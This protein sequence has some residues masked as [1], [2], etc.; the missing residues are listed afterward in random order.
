[1]ALSLAKVSPL[2]RR[3]RAWWEG[4]ELG[5]AAE[6][7]PQPAAAPPAGR[8]ETVL[9]IPEGRKSTLFQQAEIQLRERVWGVG[10]DGPGDADWVF[11]FVAPLA[12]DNKMTVAHLGAGLG[13]ITRAIAGATG[14]WTTGYEARADHAEA[15][16][17]LSTMAGQVKRAPVVGY[18]PPA[19]PKD[20][21]KC[22]AVIAVDAF[23]AIADKPALY[24]SV[25]GVLRTDGHFLFTDY[26][27]K[28]G[29]RDAPAVA[30]WLALEP[31]PVHLSTPEETREA[32]AKVRFDVRIVEEMSGEVSRLIIASWARFAET[33]TRDNFD[34][35]LGTALADELALWLA[36]LRVLESGAVGA[37]RVHAIK[38]RAQ[39]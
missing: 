4:Y 7:G 32:L 24:A 28:G 18:D 16:M 39:G 10:F 37:Y 35:R 33:L 5:E 9:P 30:D 22:H 27:L 12:L 11:R 29:A 23:R 19:L 3:M 25:F 34:R 17:E 6:A 15:G 13:G 31:A 36:R 26:L 8:K 1:M 20:A 14:A 38:H 21:S 2:A